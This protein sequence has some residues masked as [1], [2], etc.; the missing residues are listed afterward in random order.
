MCWYS[1]KKGTSIRISD[2]T[3]DGYEQRISAQIS[4]FLQTTI[5]PNDRDCSC[6]IMCDNDDEYNKLDG[7]KDIT[8]TNLRNNKQFIHF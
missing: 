7:M 2:Q 3:S 4:L 6:V 5:K 1:G 8:F